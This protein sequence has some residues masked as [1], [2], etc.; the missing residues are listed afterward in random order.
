MSAEQLPRPTFRTEIAMQ[1]LCMGWRLVQVCPSRAGLG[2]RH[3][4]PFLLLFSDPLNL[5]VDP[6]LHMFCRPVVAFAVSCRRR[7]VRS[8]PGSRCFENV[9]LSSRGRSFAHPICHLPSPHASPS[10]A[11]SSYRGLGVE[12]L[13]NDCQGCYPD[14]KNL[15]SRRVLSVVL[16]AGRSSFGKRGFSCRIHLPGRRTE[17]V[18][19]WSPGRSFR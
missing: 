11:V 14:L 8:G 3:D 2:Y 19:F 9:S 12:G 13:Q 16:A 15:F 5:L 1:P 7:S 18:A 10:R 4:S 6:S 17:L